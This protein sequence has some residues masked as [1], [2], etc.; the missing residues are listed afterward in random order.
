MYGPSMLKDWSTCD[1]LKQRQLQRGEDDECSVV[2]LLTD[3][4]EFADVRRNI[5]LSTPSFLASAA[6]DTLADHHHQQNRPH[7]AQGRE[8]TLC[9]HPHLQHRRQICG[10]NAQPRPPRRRGQLLVIQHSARQKNEGLAGPCTR[11]NLKAKS[12]CLLSCAFVGNFAFIFSCFV[13]F[14]TTCFCSNSCQIFRYGI[15]S[16]VYRARRPFP[17]HDFTPSSVRWGTGIVRRRTAQ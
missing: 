6:G 9:L 16:L 15:S 10:S 1:S 7:V 8:I 5:P 4:L 13:L 11:C 3:Q 17:Q 12:G 2:D 14:T